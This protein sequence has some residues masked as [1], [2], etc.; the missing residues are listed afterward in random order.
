MYVR[1]PT[2]AFHLEAR[3]RIYRL[4]AERT[5]KHESGKSYLAIS[6]SGSQYHQLRRESREH[7]W[8]YLSL[9]R[10]CCWIFLPVVCVSHI[11]IYFLCCI[12]GCVY[13]H[14]I[15]F[16][17]PVLFCRWIFARIFV[18]VKSIFVTIAII[19]I[20]DNGSISTNN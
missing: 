14:E 2:L 9:G 3:L 13:S 11:T 10:Y 4:Y 5:V 16:F 18:V 12:V 19:F 17:T 15:R 8:T 20:I 7:S 1:V 6:I